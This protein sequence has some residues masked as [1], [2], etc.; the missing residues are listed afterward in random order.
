M[1]GLIALSNDCDTYKRSIVVY[2][3]VRGQF[4][5]FF[6]TLLK[7]PKHYSKLIEANKNLFCR[8]CVELDFILILIFFG[9]LGAIHQKLWT[10][11]FFGL[12]HSIRQIP[13]V[14]PCGWVCL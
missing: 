7:I 13:K 6:K 14:D 5:T 8:F 11:H 2:D 10:N 9:I 3:E 12:S 1:T 4:G